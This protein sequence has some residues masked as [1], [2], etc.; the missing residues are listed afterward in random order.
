MGGRVRNLV[1]DIGKALVAMRRRPGAVVVPVLTMAI[2]IGA[3]TAIFS[4]LYVALFRALPY[5]EPD[6]LVVGRA[7][8]SGE[9]NP[10]ASAPDFYDYRERNSLLSSLSAYAPGSRRMTVAGASGGES[11]LV[12][13]VSWDLF[14]TLGV[15]PV[16][17]RSFNADEGENGGPAVAVVSYGYW[18]R[19][20]GGANA[21]LGQTLALGTTKPV[22]VGVM[23][24]GFRF[25]VDADVWI[26]MQRNAQA[27]A[28]RHFHNWMLL[29]RLKPGVTLTQA[30]QQIDRISLQLQ[31]EYPDSN[32]DKA[33]LLTP[34]QAVL[35]EDDRPSLYVLMAAVG[36]LLLVACADV[37]GLLLSRG[38]ARRTE[39]AI[40]SALGAT[41]GDLV[42]QLLA[43]SL[44]VAIAAGGLGLI[45]AI[46]M[47]SAV[48]RFVPLE[49]LGVTELPLG[50]PVLLFALGTVVLTSALFGVTPALLGAR[51]WAAGD[52]KSGGRTTE[53]RSRAL[54]RQGLVATQVAMS[55][56]LLVAAALLGR[57]LMRLGWVDPGFDTANLLTA[58]LQVSGDAY[59]DPASRV[60]FFRGILDDARAI[61]GVKAATAV[62][63]LPILDPAGNVPAWDAA[64]PPAQTSE[65]PVVCW[66]AVSPDYFKAMGIPIV[67]GRDVSAN[68][69][70]GSDRSPVVVIS[71]SVGATLFPG[72]NPIGRRLG[73]FTGSQPSILAEVV[74][75]V[76]DVHMNSLASEYSLAMYLPYQVRP[77]PVMRIAVRTA[78]DSASVA[79][80]LRQAV[81]RR[82]RGLVLVDVK[83]MDT[84]VSKSLEGFSLRAGALFLFG[85]TALLL[86]ML[87]VYG[88][89]ALTVNQ[90]RSEIGL[91]MVI[92]ASRPDM[93][94][95]VLW[96]G[97][98][99]VA[100]GL[101]IGLAAALGVGR[102][103]GDLLFNVQ[104]TDVATFGGVAVCLILAAL[105]SC[106]VPA[107]RALHV[108]PVVALRQ[109]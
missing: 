47:R 59:Q 35:S 6:R 105:A 67:A 53:T 55:V 2:G 27:N 96:R 108:D 45:I 34:L 36:V 106:L 89:L 14:R 49:G 38:A 44:V 13:P 82:D 22:I 77:Q 32:K 65:A 3:S 78:G 60:R 51:G 97:L 25:A 18:Q 48:L 86:A 4:A 91:R 39:I 8:F 42:R 72:V 46:W 16:L 21:V 31:R 92:G 37:A 85:A 74:G 99:P 68:D 24:R 19:S 43:E 101:L 56:V 87:G 33:L 76:G 84:V 9:I 28:V 69:V 109:E 81:A 63:G 15:G 94:R 79:G 30:Q 23:P 64:H 66:R 71:R 11:V 83:T 26:P 54:F 20:L 7:T 62:S 61:P 93:L 95:W 12:N 90:R 70:A 5:P 102:L 98:R 40:R 88:V 50:G 1:S 100:V 29:G 41:R 10:W 73:I 17:G 58:Q 75:I 103:L 104:P 52:L 80:A 107:W 57:S